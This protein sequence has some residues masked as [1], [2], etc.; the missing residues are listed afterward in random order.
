M[1]RKGADKVQVINSIVNDKRKHDFL[2]RSIRNKT[3]REVEKTTEWIE[4]YAT[5]QKAAGMISIL[6]GIFFILNSFSG[7]TG[8]AVAEG[9]GKGTSGILGLVFVVGGILVFMV[10]DLEGKV[11]TPTKRELKA[12]REMEQGIR[13]GKKYAPKEASSLLIQ[14]GYSLESAKGD[15]MKVVREGQLIRNL[16]TNKRPSSAVEL[17]MGSK[18]YNPEEVIKAILYDFKERQFKEYY[19]N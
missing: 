11:K 7:I 19:S 15:H 13:S 9:I 10:E 14:A 5:Y 3:A 2:K 12:I 6:I 4:R 16:P 1:P 18:S 8:F 17:D